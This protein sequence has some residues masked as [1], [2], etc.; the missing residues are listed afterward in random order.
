MAVASAETR[1]RYYRRASSC[2]DVVNEETLLFDL[3]SID[4]IYT[5]DGTQKK[6]FCDDG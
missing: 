6:G 3:I 2:R 1:S 5:R 4:F